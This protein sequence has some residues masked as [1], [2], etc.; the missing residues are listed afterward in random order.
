MGTLVGRG[1]PASERSPRMFRD[2]DARG[3]RDGHDGQDGDRG[4]EDRDAENEK[5]DVFD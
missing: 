3:A 5:E 2:R 4:A 1:C